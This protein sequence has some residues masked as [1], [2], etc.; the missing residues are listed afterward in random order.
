MD[1]KAPVPHY[2][3]LAIVLHWIIAALLV[4][5]LALGWRMTSLPR[6]AVMFDAFQLHKSIG[7]MV[8]ALS[9][10]RV[11]VR[12]VMPRP[13]PVAGPRWQQVLAE[14][15]HGLLYVFMIGAPITGWIVVS[16]A[17]VA[18]ATLLFHTVPLPHLP[19][20]HGWHDGAEGSHWALAWLGLALIGL[21]IA[22]ALK[23]QFAANPDERVAGRMIPLAP[24]RCGR[25]WLWRWAV[26]RR[27]SRCPG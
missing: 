20:P 9:L 24:G 18:I 14:A 21:H 5:Q 19:V 23:H 6:S 12:V 26:W 4:F 16:S 10:L 1:G 27:P 8:L 3:P 11:V 7:I 13:A 2:R 25:R 17:P 15:V 22:G